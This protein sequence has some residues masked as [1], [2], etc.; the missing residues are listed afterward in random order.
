MLKKYVTKGLRRKVE[1]RKTNSVE[2]IHHK[3]VKAYPLPIQLKELH[4]GVIDTLCQNL[5][6]Q[7]G[8]YNKRS[9]ASVYCV[10]VTS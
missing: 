9:I 4:A 10:Q 5:E 7:G 3:G 1:Q 2:E 6:F 8:C